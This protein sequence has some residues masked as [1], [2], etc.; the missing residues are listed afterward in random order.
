MS[1][2]DVIYLAHYVSQP[3]EWTNSDEFKVEMEKM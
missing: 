3:F 2:Q 1:T